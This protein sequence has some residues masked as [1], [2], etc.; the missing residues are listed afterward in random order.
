MKNLRHCRND[1]ERNAGKMKHPGKKSERTSE[2]NA[3]LC[4]AG[5][6]IIKG[7]DNLEQKAFVI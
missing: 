7:S 4:F 1:G 6:L 2:K 3:I 5:G